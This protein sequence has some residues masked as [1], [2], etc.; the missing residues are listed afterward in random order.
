[1]YFVG[2]NV[3]LEHFTFFCNILKEKPSETFWNILQYPR[4]L[5][6]ILESFS[7]LETFRKI[8]NISGKS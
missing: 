2:I 8:L 1:M 4:I 6:K 3:F 5:W 7:N